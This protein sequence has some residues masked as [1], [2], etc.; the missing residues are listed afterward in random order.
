MLSPIPSPDE[1]VLTYYG[2]HI[3]TIG[4]ALNKEINTGSPVKNEGGEYWVEASIPD[5]VSHIE[6]ELWNWLV[7]RYLKAGWDIEKIWGAEHTA[8]YGVVI[9]IKATA[10]TRS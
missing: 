10:A 9:G 1:R 8:Q 3:D 5:T 2:K 4:G 7:K 6:D